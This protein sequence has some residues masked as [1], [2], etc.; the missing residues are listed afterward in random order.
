MVSEPI[1]SSTGASAGRLIEASFALWLRSWRPTFW[2]GVLYGFAALLPGLALSGLG[3]DLLLRMLALSVQTL[4]PDLRLPI[5]LPPADPLAMFD[6]LQAHLLQPR[7]WWLIAAS[8]L[9]IVATT[10]PLLVRQAAIA[11]GADPGLAAAARRGLARTPA[12]L[13]AWLLYT[14]IVVALALPFVALVLG[15]FWLSLGAG[16]ALLLLA[17]AMV[18]VGGLLASVP[19][20]W[21]GVAF[22]FAP[23]VAAL[24]DRA[25]P[26]HAQLRSM[27]LLRGH[28]WRSAAVVSMPLLIYLGAG[29]TVSSL[30]LMFCGMLAYAVGGWAGLFDPAWLLWS[31][32]LAIPLQA[33]LLPLAFAGG[34][35]MFDDLRLRRPPAA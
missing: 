16:P 29:G 24:E 30:L 26:L 32:L 13:V 4:A 18:L 27:R 1:A 8:V 11:R 21:A 2:F 7:L 3:S 9:G 25:G 23:F 15:A 12:T 28:W 10:T 34:V 19:L 20:A 14:L 22:G 33:V 6:A 35:V 17:V 5:P 31:Q